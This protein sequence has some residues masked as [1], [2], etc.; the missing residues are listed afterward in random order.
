MLIQYSDLQSKYNNLTEDLEAKDESIRQA[1]LLQSEAENNIVQLQERLDQVNAELIRLQDQ[2][3]ESASADIQNLKPGDVI[4]EP[5]SELSLDSYFCEMDI[6]VGDKIYE[7][8]NGKSYRENNDILLSELC[9]LKLLHYNFQ[10]R[11]QVGEMVVNRRIANDVLAVFKD[12]FREEYEIQS[13]FLVDNYWSGDGVSTD[14]ASIDANN[15]SCFNYREV[16]GGSNLSKHAYGCAID[17][18][19]QQNP[20]VWYT[21]EGVNWTHTNASQ[22]I[23]RSGLPHMITYGDVCYNIFEEYGF[24]WGGNWADPIDYQHFEKELF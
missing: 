10:H 24:E 7:R 8:I 5:I 14:T 1:Q 12:L 22:Y 18:N 9:Y 2:I 3:D 6:E 11:I 19:P 15:T 17:I 16:T 23:D 21:D 13:M 20:Y 4:T